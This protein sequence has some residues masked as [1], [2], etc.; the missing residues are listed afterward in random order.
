MSP[1]KDLKYRTGKSTMMGMTPILWSQWKDG[2]DLYFQWHKGKIILIDADPV[3]DFGLDDVDE[4]NP[5]IL[6]KEDSRGRG[7]YIEFSCN[8]SQ[9]PVEFFGSII[10]E[11]GE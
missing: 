2:D 3:G 6:L 4:N 5:C 7:Y 9:F 8:G 11:E 1:V 10:K